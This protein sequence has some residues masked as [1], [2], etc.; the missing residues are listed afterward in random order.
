M[1]CFQSTPIFVDFRAKKW[2]PWQRP[3]DLGLGY[4]FIWS[5][6]VDS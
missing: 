3:L 4:V 5:L 6:S 2:L 1:V